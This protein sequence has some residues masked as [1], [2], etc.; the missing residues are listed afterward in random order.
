MPLLKRRLPGDAIERDID[1]D[2]VELIV[3][4]AARNRIEQPVG[5]GVPGDG[6]IESR[7]ADVLDAPQ[8]IETHLL[9]LVGGAVSAVAQRDGHEAGVVFI[10]RRVG[11]R[12]AIE[13]IV[14]VPALEHVVAA[15]PFQHVAAAVADNG[16]P[17]FEP[18][19]CSKP[20]RVSVSTRTNC[21]VSETENLARGSA[22]NATLVEL[23]A[24][25]SMEIIPL[26]GSQLSKLA[27]S[28]PA[29]PTK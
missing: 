7:T 6:V 24:V 11:L 22:A 20:D 14:A 17:R 5:F 28:L 29:P 18:R 2:R 25:G 4:V 16:F 13:R 1:A 19:T 23:D 3:A 15:A 21:P 27:V 9:V 10:T 26:V 12:P 8:R